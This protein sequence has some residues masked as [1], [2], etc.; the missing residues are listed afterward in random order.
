M[1]GAS[2]EH[3]HRPTSSRR[4]SSR[5]TCWS[6]RIA[7]G[8]DGGPAAARASGPAPVRIGARPAAID[9][10]AAALTTYLREEQAILAAATELEDAIDQLLDRPRPTRPLTARDCRVAYRLRDD[11]LSGFPYLFD[12]L[13]DVL[14]IGVECTRDIIDI[15]DRR[16]ATAA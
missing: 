12:A 3:C 1:T 8:S 11:H 7:S 4:R 9:R 13:D 16:A 6:C 10:I 14:G 15:F 5:R 2:T